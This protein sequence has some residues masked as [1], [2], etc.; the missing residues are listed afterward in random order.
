MHHWGASA[1]PLL[2]KAHHTDLSKD[3]LSERCDPEELVSQGHLRFS[4]QLLMDITLLCS[5][6]VNVVALPK[7]KSELLIYLCV[8]IKL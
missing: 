5:E 7:G 8:P 3:P 6:C 2:S 4:S 1:G